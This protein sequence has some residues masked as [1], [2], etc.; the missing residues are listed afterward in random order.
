MEHEPSG[1]LGDSYRSG[2]FVAGNSITATR[3]HPHGEEPAFEGDG[4]VFHDRANF[5][6]ELALSVTGLALPYAAQRHVGHVG[7]PTGGAEYAVRPSTAYDITDAV[8]L[9]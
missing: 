3:N 6:G 8:V 7:T 1:L 4:R 9:V 2:D 5:D